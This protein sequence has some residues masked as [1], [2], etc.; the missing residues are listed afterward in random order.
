MSN[1]VMDNYNT[2]TNEENC[3]G[4]SACHLFLF[5][6]SASQSAAR[7]RL[8]QRR[9]VVERDQDALVRRFRRPQTGL[10]GRTED[11]SLYAAAVH[12]NGLETRQPGWNLAA[13]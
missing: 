2:H 1:V 3:S 9:F 4:L 10:A 8:H 12:A 7:A 11:H 5:A 13:E 6:K